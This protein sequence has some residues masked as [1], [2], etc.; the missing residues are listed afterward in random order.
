MTM[1]NL[2]DVLVT[3]DHLIGEQVSGNGEYNRIKLRPESFQ[4]VCSSI[5]NYVARD[6]QTS[7][8]SSLVSN[9]ENNNL[10]IRLYDGILDS[11]MNVLNSVFDISGSLAK[12]L[13][14]KQDKLDVIVHR[15]NENALKGISLIDQIDEV[16]EEPIEFM[17]G[18]LDFSDN[19]SEM[20]SIK[21]DEVYETINRETQV[22]LAVKKEA[23]KAQTDLVT[24]EQQIKEEVEQSNHR[25]QEKS[26]EHAAIQ[27]KKEEA[28]KRRDKIDS[29]IV[30]AFTEQKKILNQAKQSYTQI[31]EDVRQ[32]ENRLREEARMQT[33]EN[34]S[35]I[36]QFQQ[37]IDRDNSD[38][39]MIEEENA[40]KEAI[41]AALSGPLE[42]GIVSPV[43]D[44]SIESDTSFQTYKKI[45]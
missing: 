35:K 44:N 34:E 9:I 22:T 16:Q 17:G 45:T 31:I 12:P 28:L 8:V 21:L 6:E 41:L 5:E 30:K 11:K 15:V 18:N 33:E 40:R 1:M 24:A 38:I 3:T 39:T 36:V 4:T 23:E 14:L 10:D 27:A 32:K 25:L 20:E 26:T 2:A 37:S 43:V 42:L 19:H 29:D 7:N 13:N